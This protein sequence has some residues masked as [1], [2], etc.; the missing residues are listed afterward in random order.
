[1]IYGILGAMPDEVRRLSQALVN[2]ITK[3][4]ADVDFISGI[5]EGRRLV[6][7]C[8]GMGK[9]N[10]AA[11]TQILISVFGAQRIVFSGI[12]GNLSPRLEIGDVV[13]SDE[14]C[15]HDI[16]DLTLKNTG[17]VAEI[18]HADPALV[19]AA[20]QA[21]RTLGIHALTG[22]IATGE[23]F[24]CDADSKADITARCHPLCVE[25]EGAA[26]AQVAK[27]N[28][29]PFVVVRAMSDDADEAA[30]EKLVVKQFDI[31]DYCA[32][33]AAIVLEIVRQA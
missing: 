8:A 30:F 2:P 31:S 13:I 1:M 26:V 21:C 17:L 10:A 15:H 16:D 18:Y 6:V 28:G 20:E 14:L 7:C 12:A 33:A 27:K 5:Y 4:V 24:I 23:K 29:V 3:K 32:T 25:M 9:V 19:T 22:R 11:A